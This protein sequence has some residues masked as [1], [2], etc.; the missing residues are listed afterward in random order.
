MAHFDLQ[1]NDDDE[2][3]MCVR[4]NRLLQPG[5]RTHWLSDTQVHVR[6]GAASLAFG[7]EWSRVVEWLRHDRGFRVTVRV[8]NLMPGF[9]IERLPT[10]RCA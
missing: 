8:Y 1:T 3:D 9:L 10:S 2:Y 7:A 4:L 6:G 5:E